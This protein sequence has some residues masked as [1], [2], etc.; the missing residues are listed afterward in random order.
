MMYVHGIFND[1]RDYLVIWV[2][3]RD[4]GIPSAYFQR[5]FEKV[6]QVRKQKVRGT[7]LGLTF[8]RLEVEAHGGRVWVESEEGAEACSHLHSPLT[9]K[10]TICSSN[11]LQSS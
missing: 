11:T 2:Q 3:D 7:G 8:C 6:G 5:I 1:P 10:V 4:P 9:T